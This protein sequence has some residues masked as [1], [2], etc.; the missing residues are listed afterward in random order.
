MVLAGCGRIGFDTRA[1]G[2]VD[3]AEGS[4]DAVGQVIPP[5]A[6]IWLKMETNPAVGIVDSA[7]AHSVGCNGA[8]PSAAMGLHGSGFQFA[9]E[10]VDVQDAADLASGSGF[11]GAV[12]VRMNS[13]PSAITCPMTK[14]FNNASGYDTFA[15]CVDTGGDTTFDA[16]TPGGTAVSENGPPIGIGSWHHLAITWDGTTKRDYLDGTM[17]AQITTAIGAGTQPVAVGAA[18]GQYFIDGTLDDALYYTRAL[19]QAEIMQLATP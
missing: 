3:A 4:P 9:M 12:W 8:C 10:Q 15:L 18:R 6:K 13:V 16:E 14:P 11:T 5:G 19:T 7:G 2:D 17:V 1:A